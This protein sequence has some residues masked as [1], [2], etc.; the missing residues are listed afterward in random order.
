MQRER[1]RAV[2]ATASAYL[3][4][5][6]QQALNRESS[7]LAERTH[8]IVVRMK[9]VQNPGSCSGEGPSGPGDVIGAILDGGPS[10]HVLWSR[11]PPQPMEE[12]VC[13]DCRGWR[14]RFIDHINM[15]LTKINIVHEMTR[16][17]LTL[18]TGNTVAEIVS[19]SAIR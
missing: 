3:H 13:N 10:M 16:N 7:W 2:L 11:T 9:Q 6:A 18:A 4:L 5:D 8:D 14:Y 1:C 17:L 12:A 19:R 15:W